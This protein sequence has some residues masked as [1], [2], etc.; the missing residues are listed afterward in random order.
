MSTY[1]TLFK[2]IAIYEFIKSKGFK[3]I[4]EATKELK[5]SF[6]KERD[7]FFK[8]YYPIYLK[9]NKN[10]LIKSDK[11]YIKPNYEGY[12][13]LLKERIENTIAHLKI[14]PKT[15]IGGLKE[16]YQLT[17]ANFRTL[18]LLG[19]I[20]NIQTKRH[21]Y[22]IIKKQNINYETLATEVR[23]KANETVNNYKH[24]NK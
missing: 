6:K 24:K 14:H 21:P 17:D 23:V 9:T 4:A 22:W 3:S 12:I 20:E 10:N 19:I 18:R 16:L 7:V 2:E 11:P 5:S 8:E 15:T 1:P 13:D